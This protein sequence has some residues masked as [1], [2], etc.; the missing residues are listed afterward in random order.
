MIQRRT[1]LVRL[2]GVF[3]FFKIFY[4]PLQASVGLHICEVFRN[5]F[6]NTPT[7]FTV[8]EKKNVFSTFFRCNS[9]ETW[10]DTNT[11]GYQRNDKYAIGK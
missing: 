1:V 11:S 10:T 9:I 2:E 7:E 6:K 5:Y 3:L 4:L 8:F